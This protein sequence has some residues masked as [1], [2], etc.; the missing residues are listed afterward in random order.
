M[1]FFTQSLILSFILSIIF[2]S[3]AIEETPKYTL[4][5]TVS[6]SDGGKITLSPQSPDYKAG[7]VVTLTAEP[8]EHWVFKQWEGDGSGSST[9]LQ[10]TMSS[11]KSVVGVFVKRDYPLTLT[12]EGEGTVEEKIVTNPGGKVYPHGTSVELTPKPNNGWIFSSWGGDLTG[13]ETP[14]K[15]MIDKEK[16]VTVK[17]IRSPT[18]TALNCSAATNNGTLTSGVAVTGVVNIVI[19]YSGAFGGTHNGQTVTSTGVTGLTATLAAGTF[20]N[21]S[22][23]LT[24]TITGTP[25]AVGTASFAINIGGQTCVLTRSVISAPIVIAAGS[26]FD[27]PF[28][29]RDGAETRFAANGSVNSIFLSGSDEYLAGYT[30]GQFD[31]YAVIWKNGTKTTL[32]S[33]Y[34]SNRANSIFINGNDVYV[35]GS[36][37]ENPN[38]RNA[39]LW[40]NGV[41]VYLDGGGGNSVFVQNN[42]AFVAGF[43]DGINGTAARFWKN[44][45]ATNLVTP[46]QTNPSTTYSIATS[47]F[48]NGSDVYVGGEQYSEM[49]ADKTIARIWKNGSPM[50]LTNMPGNSSI[51]AI[52]VNGTDV[53]TAGV[54][55]GCVKPGGG[56]TG[57]AT[58]WKNG[59]PVYL[60]DCTKQ[61]GVA[62]TIYIKG[63]DVYVGG[64][65]RNFQENGIPENGRGRYVIWKNG[66][67]YKI[68]SL[69]GSGDTKVQAVVVK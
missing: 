1:N 51:N 10:I 63:S 53:Y 45:I 5:T 41:P 30:E 6:P 31:T 17:F 46:V 11:D 35:A 16:K 7:D 55:D 42:N 28:V 57:I 48:I 26:I 4:S 47:V 9:P 18:V 22:G 61:W 60:S 58:Y 66:A 49:G 59:V 52:F 36:G 32:Q 33:K 29:L 21:G 64:F 14:K 37:G 23:N 68:S 13:A 20:A 25:S 62:Q 19:P 34:P 39:I 24:Y 8:N 2:S 15:I 38:S 50:A 40:K 44:G 54:A 67:I 43:V 3:C 56:Y 65:I 27:I 69:G 12:I